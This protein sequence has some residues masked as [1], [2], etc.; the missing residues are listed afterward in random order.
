MNINKVTKM[1]KHIRSLNKV[2]TDTFNFKPKIIT[3]KNGH[4]CITLPD[5]SKITTSNSPSDHRS[6][7]NLFRDIKLRL[8]VSKN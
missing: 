3:S 7:L 4:L 2:I 6:R 8:R 1:K 5:N